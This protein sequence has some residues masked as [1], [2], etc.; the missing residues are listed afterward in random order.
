VSP[1]E[2]LRSTLRVITD[3]IFSEGDKTCRSQN[4][5]SFFWAFPGYRFDTWMNFAC[6]FGEIA[7]L[8]RDH[9]S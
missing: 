9:E 8:S 1:T 6:R 4:F 3:T 5:A 7:E 2:S